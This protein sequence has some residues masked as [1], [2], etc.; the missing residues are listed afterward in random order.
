MSRADLRRPCPCGK[1]PHDFRHLGD[2]PVA[3]NL[4]DIGCGPGLYAEAAIHL[5]PLLVDEAEGLRAQV[6]VLRELLSDEVA[7]TK[8]LRQQ[9]RDALTP[10]QCPL[11]GIA[12]GK[13]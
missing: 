1:T 11:Q 9:L 12:G 13:Q 5:F 7:T 2:V 10:L 3:Q 6:V 8:R 4:L